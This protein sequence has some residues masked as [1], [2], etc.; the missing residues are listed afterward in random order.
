VKRPITAVLATDGQ[1]RERRLANQRLPKRR[2]MELS[3]G[4]K[5]RVLKEDGGVV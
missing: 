3:E 1:G 5:G 2:H 4:C